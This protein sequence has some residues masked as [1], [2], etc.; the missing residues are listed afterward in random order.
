MARRWQTLRLV[1]KLPDDHLRK[2]ISFRQALAIRGIVVS[3]HIRW[4]H[5]LESPECLHS[6]AKQEDEKHVTSAIRF[7]HARKSALSHHDKSL[8]TVGLS[9]VKS[10]ERYSVPS[11]RNQRHSHREAVSSRLRP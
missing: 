11:K 5:Q 3:I 2:T 4:M 8:A 10:K 6:Q 9:P 7:H 1:Q